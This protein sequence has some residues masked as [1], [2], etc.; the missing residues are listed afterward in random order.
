MD[1]C[2]LAQKY[3][4]DG[5][6]GGTMGT[7]SDTDVLAQYAAYLR[8]LVDLTGSRPL[9]IVVDAGNG[10]A[11]MTTPTIPVLRPLDM[12]IGY[13][14]EFPWICGVFGCWRASMTTQ[15]ALSVVEEASA[16]LIGDAVAF[17][18]GKAA[19]ETVFI[20]GFKSF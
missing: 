8:T 9:K 14:F 11:A 4:A 17:F 19:G 6:P 1:I 12:V 3:L 10:M 18:G 16:A 15:P 2:G 7:I 20:N 5:I 13:V